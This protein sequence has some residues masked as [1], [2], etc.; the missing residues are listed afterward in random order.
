VQW[1]SLESALLAS[2]GFEV[3]LVEAVEHEEPIF[4]F[5][6]DDFDDDD[7]FDESGVEVI[8]VRD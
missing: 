8:Y 5:D 1:P 4:E 7:D 3:A 6:S 2:P